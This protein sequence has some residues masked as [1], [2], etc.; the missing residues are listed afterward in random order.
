VL[1]RIENIISSLVT[2]S[3]LEVFIKKIFRLVFWFLLFL[4]LI[5][6]PIYF[7]FVSVV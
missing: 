4:P 2:S 1:S 3:K 6:I 5:L 7:F